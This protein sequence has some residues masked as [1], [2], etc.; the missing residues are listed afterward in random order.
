MN[1][2]ELKYYPFTVSLDKFSASC[3]VLSPKICVPNEKKDIN[4]KAFNMLTNKN[5]AKTIT[6][7][8]SCDFK[9]KFNRTT[10]KSNQ[11]RNN[12]T[13]QCECKNCYKCKKDYILNLSTCICENSKYLKGIAD[14]SVSKCGK[15]LTV[16]DIA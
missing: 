1:P 15:I 16:T 5:Q 3:N 11:K 12:K 7:Y 2:V 14:T 9:C 10:C 4:I 6:K 8:I 13:C